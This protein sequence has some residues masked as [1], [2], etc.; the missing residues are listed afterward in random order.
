[1]QLLVV[2]EDAEVG[3]QLV[4]MVK[5]YTPHECALAMSDAAALLWANAHSD[6][7]VLIAQLDG[8]ATNALKL[9]SELSDRFPGLQTMFLPGYSA[10][11]QR[12][13]VAK[14]KVFPEPI[15]GDLLLDAIERAA[16][17][18]GSADLF[19]VLDVLQMCCLSGRSGAV[20]LVRGD[21]AGIVFLRDGEIVHA[22]TATAAGNGALLDIVAWSE[23]EFAYDESITAPARSIS[24]AWDETLIGAIA[25]RKTLNAAATTQKITQDI[26]TVPPRVPEPDRGLRRLLAGF[27]RR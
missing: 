3:E 10:A 27:R 11:E 9:G 18:Q 25:K 4:Q 26:P 7:S 1:M 8:E 21:D 15:N 19:H 2:H 5:D 24:G 22:E 20:Q 12:L 23:V 13:E 14:T 6:C 16:A 17:A